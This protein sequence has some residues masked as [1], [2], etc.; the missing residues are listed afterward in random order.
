MLTNFHNTVI[1]IG[2]TSN[3]VKRVWEH[4]QKL[5]TGFSYK[6]NLNRLVYFEKLDDITLAIQREKQLKSRNRLRKV[7]LIESMNPKWED[8]YSQI[9]W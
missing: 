3:L 6:Y 2:V 7:K 4:K 8:L 9:I 1:Y 5:V